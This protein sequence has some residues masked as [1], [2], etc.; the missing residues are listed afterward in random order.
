MQEYTDENI[1]ERTVC[2]PW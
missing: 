1:R 2:R